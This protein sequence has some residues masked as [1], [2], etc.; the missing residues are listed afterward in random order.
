MEYYING[1]ESLLFD[2]EYYTT[3]GKCYHLLI[4][5][6]MTSVIKFKNIE[7]IRIIVTLQISIIL[8][9]SVLH[10]KD[11]GDDFLNWK[12]HIC[13]FLRCWNKN[14]LSIQGNASAV[15]VR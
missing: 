3:R 15:D 6:I 8:K 10:S 2:V 12:A 7:W 4:D 14:I 1:E 9:N 13:I 11:H 5:V